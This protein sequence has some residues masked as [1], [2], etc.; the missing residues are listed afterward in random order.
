MFDAET[1]FWFDCE[2][3]NWTTFDEFVEAF[4]LQYR[5]DDIQERLCQEIKHRT[6]GLNE[7][8][9]IYLTKLRVLLDRVRSAIALNVQQDRA[10]RNMHL[11]YRKRI[12]QD[13]FAS[14]AELQKLGKREEERQLQ[15]RAYKSP[16]LP[17]ES[18]FPRSAYEA[19]MMKAQMNVQD[20]VV[21]DVVT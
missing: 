20:L 14:F 6:Q 16:P 9:S 12:S 1:T 13:S 17:E 15:D 10:Y 7:D 18:W 8:V 5:V 11:S 21:D 3:C 19:P 4:R 2:P